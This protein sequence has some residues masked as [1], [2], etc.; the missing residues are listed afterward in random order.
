M[1]PPST[2]S[3]LRHV[4]I[5]LTLMVLAAACGSSDDGGAAPDDSGEVTTTIDV[6]AG[7]TSEATD[8]S[9]TTAAGGEST[10]STTAS[11]QSQEEPAIP[12]AF[13][14]IDGL[15]LDLVLVDSST[16]EV[17]QR[18]LG[19]GADLGA[20]EPEGGRQLLTEVAPG[21]GLVWVADCCEPAVGNVYGVDVSA[22]TPV[23]ESA[24]DIDGV[25]PVVSPDGTLVAV[26]VL[27]IGVTVHD[28]E[29]GE[30]LVDP[31]SVKNVL[32]VPSD[33]IGFVAARPLAWLDDA[34]LAVGISTDSATTITLVSVENLSSPAAV[35]PAIEID[36]TVVAAS[37][38][39]DGALVSVVH[40]DGPGTAS[41][42][43]HDTTTGEEVA[44]FDL[45]PGTD[46]IDYDP[47][48]TFLLVSTAEGLVSWIGGGEEEDLAE[49]FLRAAWAADDAT[50]PAVDGPLELETLESEEIAAAGI[51]P[52]GGC[53]FYLNGAEGS[54]VFFS[55]LDGAF[56]V[57]D[58]EPEVFQTE[59][60]DEGPFTGERFRASF[61]DVS[62]PVSS[63]IESSER[64]A[65]LV[66]STI[67]G[68]D[69]TS[70]DG[71]IW[72]GV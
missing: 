60:P 72:C 40:T 58:G 44:A 55:G 23:P 46:H 16:G 71:I 57:I 8:G 52:P 20:P 18:T 28:A 53:S 36:G 24:V 37:T 11:D 45:P 49:G 41:G 14:A 31:A 2:P 32:S 30:A 35:G 9:A 3:Y 29:T 62:D 15:T 19:W 17:V 43:V 50:P 63:S 13:W 54:T 34:T 61:R 65:T 25:S 12:P 7:G 66:V 38:R 56:A 70:V 1:T 6:D 42:A 10:S 39:A 4:S 67:D 51:D 22:T 69:E 26:Q 21:A 47:T 68:G 48:G 5:L 33:A 64:A 59:R 27:D